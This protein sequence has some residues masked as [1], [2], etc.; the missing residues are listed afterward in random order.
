MRVCVYVCMYACVCV[1]AHEGQA[2][3][4]DM[5]DM[6]NKELQ[7]VCKTNGL[8]TMFRTKRDLIERLETYNMMA[9]EVTPD[10]DF[11][12]Y[13]RNVWKKA[14]NPAGTNRAQYFNTL[15]SEY[16][17]HNTGP[18]RIHDLPQPQ[19]EEHKRAKAHLATICR[20]KNSGRLLYALP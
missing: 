12:M 8:S 10:E 14:K 1:C 20:S 16:A 3:W 9:S 18:L 13:V 11:F 7:A 2:V 4:M 6:S 5:Y 17:E 15:A 19:Q